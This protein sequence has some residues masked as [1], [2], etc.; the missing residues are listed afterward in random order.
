[1]YE[2]NKRINAE[3]ETRYFNVHLL[4]HYNRHQKS[5]TINIMGQRIQISGTA[6]LLS[7]A[8]LELA[9]DTCRSKSWKRGGTV[10]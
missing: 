4:R 1:M 9:C 3:I 7:V 10:A 6:P 2:E 5:S 8:K